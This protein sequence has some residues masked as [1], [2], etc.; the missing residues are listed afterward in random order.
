MN[1]TGV[2]GVFFLTFKESIRAKWL[3]IFSIIFFL[4]A[5]DIPDLVATQGHI[6]PPNYLITFLGVLI[7]LAFPVIPLLSLPMGAT[8]IVDDREAGT[9]QYVLSNPISKSEFFMGKAAGLVV[10][11]TIAVIFGFGAAAVVSYTTDFAKYPGMTYLIAF[12]VLLNMAMLSLGFIISDFA[13]RKATAL[14]VGIFTWLFF[15]AFANVDQLV[16]VLNVRFG[17]STAVG[18]VLADPVELARIL[19]A[20]QLGLCTLANASQCGN[21]GLYALVFF[22]SNT[23]EVILLALLAWIAGLFVIGFLIFR[24]QDLS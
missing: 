21:L 5:V 9:L 1:L 4:L 2:W 12:A 13:K 19:T 10:A 3:I 17:E 24:H 16:N 11:T 8:S 15:T 6:L 20:A 18:L 7:S 22:K 14:V 23:Y